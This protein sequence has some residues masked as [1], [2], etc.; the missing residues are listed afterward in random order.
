DLVVGE[1]S[2]STLFASRFREN[3]AR[4]LLLPRRRP[5]SRTPLWQQR[6][7]SADLLAVA[8]RH[9]EFPILLETYRECLQDVFELPGLVDLM[10]AIRSR[11]VRVV[12][13]DTA[14]P[15][16]F[17]SSLAFAYVASFIYEGDAPLAERRAQAL[18]L[19][20]EMLAELLGSDE[21]R[22][23][24]DASSLASLEAQLQV[25]DERRW[26]RDADEAHDLLRRL[27]DLTRDE[28]SA[29]SVRPGGAAGSPGF[30]EVLLQQRRAVTVRI[31]GEDRLVAAE[32]AGRYRDALGANPP[33]GLP[34]AFLEP[35][36]DPL[37]SI[38]GR[39]A[40]THG[41]F[42]S[43][44]PAARLGLPV[45]VVEEVLTRRA[46]SGDLIRGAFRPEGT[47]RE[48]C[49]PEVLRLLRQRSLAALRRE[50][51]PT[52]AEALA[53]FLPAWHGVGGRAGGAD[54]LLEVVGQ[55]Q[56]VALPLSVLEADVLAARVAGYSPAL[57]DELAAAGEVVWVGVGPLGRADGRVAL[58][59][60]ERASLL[61][62]AFRG[63][64]AGGGT[65]PD[66]DEHD[67]LRSVLSERGAC[68]FREL[69]APAGGDETRT[70][71]ALWDLVWAGEVTNDS[72]APLR[73]LGA[74]RRTAG[75]R[76]S[77]RA[78]HI[79]RGRPRV[80]SLR[81]LGPPR[82]QGRW[83]LVQSELLGV[84]AGSGPAPP[85]G[86]PAGSGPAPPSGGPAGSGTGRPAGSVSATERTHALALLLLERHGVLT[87]E[88]VRGE[89][90]PG[91]FS[92]VYPVLRALEEQG[93]IRRGYFVAGLGGAQFALPGAVD[94]L[95]ASRVED[96]E[97]GRA[98]EEV[99]VLAATDPANPYGIA[100]PWPSA[101]AEE[102]GA[103]G[104]RP[105]RVAGAWVVLLDGRA[106]LYVERGGR[107]LIALRA[108]DGTWEA[109]AVEALGRLL[110]DRRL[111]R[112]S[113][114]RC[115]PAL[116]SVL[117]AAGFIPAPAGLVRYR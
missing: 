75:A 76:G 45:A 84:S 55:L 29:R 41:P 78:H 107:G 61:L 51:E 72:F 116:V 81:A 85:S 13:V 93:R 44:E 77:G 87:R 104:R 9:G 25:I 42:L 106:S 4:A 68:F 91:G 105:Q 18:T 88:A 90:V 82:A 7:R 49:D 95:R 98:P 56:G 62:G 33:P 66:D 114:E 36:D 32:D 92:A 17:A 101:G 53:R 86:G 110:T 70:L 113:V 83:S 57:L 103:G 21:L 15:S 58:F 102:G 5:G 52:S 39:W 16:A 11:A 1:L 109:A 115:D 94:R 108:L 46:G 74:T 50:V 80:G 6:Q 71:D 112:M 38:L 31:A 24:I 100:L 28:L 65:R 89:G 67:R 26:A 20:R 2:G 40:R 54:R 117:E 37:G 27:G 73:A 19:D 59:L 23:L 22:E 14:H 64:D 47:E 111:R 99:V 35:V 43:A 63:A 10:Q 97:P 79:G 30:A 96:G 8:S 48:W 60:R 34:D 12:A 69:T 3:A